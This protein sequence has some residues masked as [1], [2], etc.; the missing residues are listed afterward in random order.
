MIPRKSHPSRRLEYRVAGLIRRGGRWARVALALGVVGAAVQAAP[1]LAGATVE[2]PE[3]T[4]AP[5]RGLVGDFGGFGVQ[6]NQHLYADI[7]GPPPGVA[8]LEAKVVALAPPF[9]RVFFNTTAWTFPD[10]MA[11]FERT[12]ALAHR[13]DARINIT[14]QGSGFAFAMANMPRFADVIGRVLQDPS[15]DYVW[16]TLFNEPNSTRL[17]LAQYEQVYRRLD[18]A[19]RERGLRGRVRF[20]GGDLLGTASPLG[21][22][23]VDWFRYLASRMGDLLDAWSVHIYWD[24]W[25]ASKIDRRLESEVRTIFATIPAEQRRPL[26]VTE[27]GVRGVPTF[28]GEPNPQ[29]GLWPDGTPMTE[30]TTAAFQQAWFM[31]RAAQLGFSATA[32]WDLYAAR[33]DAGEQ[34]HS[35]IGPGAEGWPER[36]VYRLLQLLTATTRPKGGRIAELVR[37]PGADRSKLV[38][39]YLSPGGD[40]TLLGLD[41]DGGVIGTSESAPVSYDLGGLPPSTRF[42]LVLWNADGTGTNAEIGFVDSSPA[43]TL[44]IS[45]PLRAVF[46]LTT[47]PLDSPPW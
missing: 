47:T 11:S 33:Y 34:D 2:G 39:A 18:T 12:V 7:S 3:L 14:W 22:S 31:I 42:R 6:L 37:S 44:Q 32:K 40:V 43:G 24:F 46:A 13:A 8:A 41:T 21:Q 25:D 38:T 9:V 28:E 19:L 45:V 30:T 10:R 36:P 15:I 4:L 20:M 27:F 23:Q 17:T 26:Y 29:P 35:A 16:V 1:V 5:E